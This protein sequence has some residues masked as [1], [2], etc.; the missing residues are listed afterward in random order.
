M[1]NLD[2]KG[3]RRDFGTGSVREVTE[4]KGRFDLLPFDVI[5]ELYNYKAKLDHHK[6][7][8]KGDNKRVRRANM[9]SCIYTNIHM[10]TRVYPDMP[11]YIYDAI[12]MFI[13]VE[14][15]NSIE[16]AINSVALHFE[17]G[18]KK[19]SERNWEKGQPTMVFVD[20]GMRHLNKCL[21]GMID[22]PHYSAF[23]WNMI[24]LLW[25]VKHKPELDNRPAVKPTI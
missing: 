18:A 23:L 22:E 4:G 6:P 3:G 20:S 19:Y 7:L 2:D 12:L 8:V 14:F 21:M 17:A 24:C 5:A 25:T 1:I 10:Y 15:E 11:E 16:S 13:E 9:A